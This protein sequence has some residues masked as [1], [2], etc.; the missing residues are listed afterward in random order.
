M[1]EK[2]VGYVIDSLDADE[3]REVEDR[4]GRDPLLRDRLTAL[5]RTLSLDAEMPEPLP[6]LVLA[7][8]ARVAEEHCRRPAPP[9]LSQ[10]IAPPRR[11][12][13]RADVLVAALLLILVG[14]LL[15]PSLQQAWQAYQIKACQRNLVLFW[16]GWQRHSELHEGAFPQLKEDGPCSFAGILVPILN[17]NKLLGPEL[18]ILCPAVGKRAP[19]SRSVEDLRAFWAQNTSDQYRAAL[20]E[21][22]GNYAYPL[23]YRDGDRLVGLHRYEHD[24]QPLMADAPGRSEDSHENSL[25]HGRRGQ[26]VLYVGGNV[27]W[28]RSRT[29]G[30]DADDIY[31]NQN[32]EVAAGLS[33]DDVVLGL[34]DACPFPCRRP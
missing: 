15:F 33:R 3:L 5:K 22:G 30:P 1:D 24:G 19:D 4:L 14:G 18:S 7:T 10:E 32:N 27:R 2:L 8:L 25:N 16:N 6:R 34:G 31:L 17:D 9:R 20:R 26:N 13:R 23:G 11:S 28:L 12:F 21:V 29:V